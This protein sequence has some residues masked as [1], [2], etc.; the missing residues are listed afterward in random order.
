MAAGVSDGKID[1]L[2]SKVSKLSPM[3]AAAR[4]VHDRARRPAWLLE[5]LSIHQ[6]VTRA[7]RFSFA[8]MFASF[9]EIHDSDGLEFQDGRRPHH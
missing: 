2:A 3:S 8:H 1:T 6:Q 5:Q 7:A 4:Y 9:I